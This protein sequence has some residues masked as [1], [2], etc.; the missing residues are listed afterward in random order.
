MRLLGYGQRLR[1]HMPPLAVAFNYCVAVRLAVPHQRP[2]SPLAHKRALDVPQAAN[3][4]NNG[5]NREKFSHGG[6]P[7][8]DG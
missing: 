4:A 8:G 1:M 3:H 6:S 7:R 2:C 5:T